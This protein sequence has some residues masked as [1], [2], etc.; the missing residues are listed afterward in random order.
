MIAL[1][2]PKPFVGMKRIGKRPQ[3]S[4][5][6]YYSRII[7]IGNS[8]G[9]L[10]PSGILKDLALKEKDEVKFSIED[11]ILV[12]KKIAPFTGPFTG[13]FADMP[14]P[15]PEAWGGDMS[16]EEYVEE[17]RAGGGNRDIP[18]W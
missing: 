13:I 14:K 1:S 2:L 3:T 5:N 12:I 4:N 16:A 11:D 10:I 6:V 18:Q 7:R 15:D 9:L 17:L 8:R